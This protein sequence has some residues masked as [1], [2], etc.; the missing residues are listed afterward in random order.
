M[1]LSSTRGRPGNRVSGRQS[2]YQRQLPGIIWAP[3]GDEA[4]VIW[5]SWRRTSEPEAAEARVRLGELAAK[6]MK[7]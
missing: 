2:K 7:I 6:P 1:Q 3:K 4:R 5:R